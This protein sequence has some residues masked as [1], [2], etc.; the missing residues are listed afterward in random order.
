MTE[1]KPLSIHG[2][3]PPVRPGGKDVLRHREILAIVIAE[4]RNL[5]LGDDSA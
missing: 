3:E 1:P 4:L 5:G 2:P